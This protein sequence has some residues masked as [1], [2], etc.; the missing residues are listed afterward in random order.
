MSQIVTTTRLIKYCFF[1]CSHNFYST[2]K[3]EFYKSFRG[4]SVIKYQKLCCD[5][6]ARS[7]LMKGSYINATPEREQLKPALEECP[8]S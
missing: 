6:S 3:H 7:N 8:S 1:K 2:I 4:F 5:V